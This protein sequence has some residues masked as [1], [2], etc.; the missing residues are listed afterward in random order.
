MDD[1]LSKLTRERPKAGKKGGSRERFSKI[2]ALECLDQLNEKLTSGYPIPGI[3]KWLQEEMMEY[4]DVSRDSLVTILSRY[5][6]AMPPAQLV[7]PMSKV[8][9]QAETRVMRGLDELDELEE[10]YSIQKSRIMRYSALEAN[11]PM[12]WVAVNKDIMLA[13]TILVRRHEIKMDLGVGGGRNLGTLGIRPE[14]QAKVDKYGEDVQVAAKSPESRGRV[15]AL[16]KSLVK[17]NEAKE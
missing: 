11:A 16:A 1:K 12:P 8:A 3:A 15:L 4:T 6:N 10:L 7:A 17:L 13:A 14:L 5:R 2:K 9:V